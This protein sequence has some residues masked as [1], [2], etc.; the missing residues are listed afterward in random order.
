M[1]KILF[2]QKSKP[3]TADG[4][5]MHKDANGS[6]KVDYVGNNKV[7]PVVS[8]SSDSVPSTII[9]E[10]SEYEFDATKNYSTGDVVVKDG[11]LYEFTSNHSAG[12]WDETET[13]ETDMLSVVMEGKGSSPS[14]GEY[15]PYL[16]IN[17]SSELVS[18]GR[19]GLEF[20]TAAAA[21]QAL[22]V[23]EQDF[24]RI[25][26]DQFPMCLGVTVGTDDVFSVNLER[27]TSYEDRES[28]E[29]GG[30]VY[31]GYGGFPPKIFHVFV[32]ADNDYFES[33]ELVPVWFV[34]AYYEQTQPEIG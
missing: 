26:S 5:W 20:D 22:G 29:V 30:S 33:N 1:Q 34:S 23:S 6:M 17:P 15:E 31:A 27:H 14:G 7:Y 13:S 28:Y 24:R 9:S 3:K 11:K 18:A 8:G 21:A 19:E 25:Y 12:A 10:D 2:Y 32:E 4:L 16:R